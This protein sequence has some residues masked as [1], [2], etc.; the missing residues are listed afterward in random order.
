MQSQFRLATVLHS[1]SIS[2]VY[3]NTSCTSQSGIIAELL[4]Q[5]EA[6]AQDIFLIHR[7][8]VKI[9]QSVGS[10]NLTHLSAII[11][12]RPTTDNVKKIIEHLKSPKNKSYYIFFSNQLEEP[13]LSELAQVD[14]Y[15]VVEQIQVCFV[16]NSF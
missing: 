7:L 15:E 13:S 10:S 5:S 6:L 3:Y 1:I 16:G 2:I 9:P 11:F 4:S 12:C 8:G 14:T